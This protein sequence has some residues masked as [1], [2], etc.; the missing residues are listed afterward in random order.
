[1]AVRNT[2]GD[3]DIIMVSR[4]GQAIRFHESDVRPTGRNASGVHGMRLR[5]GDEVIAWTSPATT[6]TSS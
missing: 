3:D 2:S 5:K 1:M 4:L 6:P